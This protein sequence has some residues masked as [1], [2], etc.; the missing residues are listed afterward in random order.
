M[1]KKIV[2]G[3]VSLF[4]LSSVAHAQSGI[5]FIGDSIAYGM[6]ASGSYVNGGI[7]GAGISTG[8][9]A[10]NEI[11][12]EQHIQPLTIVEIGTNDFRYQKHSYDQLLTKYILPFS[13]VS[14]IC[15]VQIPTP[16]DKKPV[17]QKGVKNLQPTLKNWAIENHLKFV[18]FPDFNTSDRAPDGI[19]FKFE[20][21]KKFSKELI[22]KCK[23]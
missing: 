4:C 6:G 2:Y 22:D 11:H 13:K 17:I 7:V 8:N 5:A 23:T 18:S 21:Y 14:S 15:I 19:H 1:F 12:W 3:I 16:D 9:P 10:R 20:A